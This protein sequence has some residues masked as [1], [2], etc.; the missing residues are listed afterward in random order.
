MNITFAAMGC[1]LLGLEALSTALKR[2]KHKVSLVFDPSLFDDKVYFHNKTLAKIFRINQKKIVNK[3]LKTNPDIIGFYIITD[4]LNWTEKIAILLKKK[5]PNI[6]IVC[7]GIYPTSNPEN[8][9]KKAWVDIICRG[10][11]EQ[12]LL[13]LLESMSKGNINY[14][15]ENLWF[16]KEKKIIKNPIRPPMKGCDFPRYDKSLFEK[17]IP[18]NNSFII[19]TTKGCPFKCTYCSESFLQPIYE[20][21]TGRYFVRKDVDIVITEL[22]EMKQKYKF[23]TLDI[24]DNTFT[25]DKKWALD[26][27]KKYQKDIKTPFKVM[28]HPATID[29][30]VASA[31]KKAGCFKCQFGVQTMNEKIRKEVLHRPFSNERIIDGFK[32]CDK[33]K[34]PYSIDHIFNLPG[35]SEQDHIKSTYIYSYCKSLMR[36]T[37][38]WL[39]YFPGTEIVDI[40]RKMNILTDKDVE[41]INNV[42]DN[43]FYLKT[44]SLKDKKKIKAL[45]S[46][47][48]LMRAIPLLPGRFIRFVLKHK[49]QRILK[50]IPK[51]L[52]LWTIDIL[53]SIKKK[54]LE[55]LTY[56][57]YYLWQIKR[58]SNEFLGGN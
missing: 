27:C 18:M 19:V 55:G 31:L 56:L 2:K 34:I 5:A 29:Y 17:V 30:E 36:I 51:Y 24:R 26:F 16:K 21:K 53:V 47:N 3:I 43:C 49:L 28:T 25:I 58:K 11:G 54:D 44:G 13:E 7:G 38:F 22:K 9:I 40:A 45:N 14:K 57:K 39:A 10:E 4:T 52:A 46:Y 15:I 23:R 48:I 35:E 12:P 37:C 6:P 20:P 41:K 50:Y 42:E 1:E 32:A 8:L 33:A